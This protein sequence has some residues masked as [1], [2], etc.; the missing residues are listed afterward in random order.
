MLCYRSYL[1]GV[2]DSAKAR[3]EGKMTVRIAIAIGEGADH[4]V[5]QKF[6]GHSE[7]KPLKANN[8]EA[9]VKH[10]KWVSTAVLRSACALASH[11]PSW[12]WL[13]KIPSF[14]KRF[15]STL[16]KDPISCVK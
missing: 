5:L 9:H 8:P 15:A 11:A 7:L 4:V 1:T 2:R 12:Q 14:D 6:I 16:K 3:A 10:I 13:K